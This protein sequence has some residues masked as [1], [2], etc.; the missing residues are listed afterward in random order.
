MLQYN[1]ANNTIEHSV[2]E[3][4]SQTGSASHTLNYI[5][6]TATTDCKKPCIA[7]RVCTSLYPVAE[8]F[9]ELTIK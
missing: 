4:E 3:V 1:L 7:S 8:G 5:F 2:F 9:Q 6:S